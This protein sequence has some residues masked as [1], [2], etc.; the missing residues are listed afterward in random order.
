MGLTV[1]RR[2]SPG[3]S[4]QGVEQQVVRHG[5]GAGAKSLS[6]RPRKN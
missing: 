3:S 1:S 2:Q 4:W 6:W 5:A